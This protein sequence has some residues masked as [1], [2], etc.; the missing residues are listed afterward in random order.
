[1]LDPRV[2]PREHEGLVPVLVANEVRRS[3]VLAAGLDND[4]G[5][6]SHPDHIALE[7]DAVTYC[8]S[9]NLLPSVIF[10]FRVCSGKFSLGRLCDRIG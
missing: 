5:V 7:V 3:A 4:R 1:M 6:L 10:H 8:C 2:R 9:H